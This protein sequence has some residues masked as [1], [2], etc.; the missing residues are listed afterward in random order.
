MATK[1]KVTEPQLVGYEPPA[2][3]VLGTAHD[4][5]QGPFPGPTPDVTIFH[6]SR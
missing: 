2:L 3:E 5:T 4:L 1:D 6:T